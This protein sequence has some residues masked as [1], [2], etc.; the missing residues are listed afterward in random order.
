MLAANHR[1]E[2][3]QW[4]EEIKKC[5]DEDQGSTGPRYDII[6]FQVLFLLLNLFLLSV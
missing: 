3:D 5:M 2:M 6:L 4:L 1:E